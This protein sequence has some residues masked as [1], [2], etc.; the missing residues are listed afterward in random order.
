MQPRHNTPE[1]IANKMRFLEAAMELYGITVP[2]FEANTDHVEK[3]LETAKRI[4]AYVFSDFNENIEPSLTE[5][6]Q[7]L[8]GNDAETAAGRRKAFLE[9]L[10]SSGCGCGRNTCDG[11][12]D[13]CTCQ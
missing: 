2:G 13:T 11:S 10:D 4:E 8:N 5:P 1:H 12:K 3:I 7:I 6:R 9:S